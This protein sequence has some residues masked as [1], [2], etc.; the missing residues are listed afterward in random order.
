MSSG[1]HTYSRLK[2]IKIKG[3]DVSKYDEKNQMYRFAQ[4]TR[5]MLLLSGNRHQQCTDGDKARSVIMD[6]LNF[7]SVLSPLH[8]LFHL[9]SKTTLGHRNGQVE[10]MDIIPIPQT[11]KS[12]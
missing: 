10:N 5:E 7:N 4:D 9:F 1:T 12:A 8:I 11:S 6:V 3:S 2:G